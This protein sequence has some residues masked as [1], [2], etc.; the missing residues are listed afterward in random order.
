MFQWPQNQA[1]DKATQSPDL[2]PIE[3]SVVW[4]KEE[5]PQERP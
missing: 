2:T 5:S 3:K 4:A 1:F